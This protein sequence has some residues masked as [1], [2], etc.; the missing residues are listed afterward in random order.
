MDRLWEYGV[1]P[2][3]IDSNFSGKDAHF[4]PARRYAS[5]GTIVMALCPSVCVCLSVTSRCSIE[6][7]G[8]NKEIRASTKRLLPSGTLS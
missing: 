4:L 3:E 8:H 2:Y 5:P 7:D 6:T 1:I